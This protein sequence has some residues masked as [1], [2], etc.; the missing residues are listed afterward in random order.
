MREATNTKSQIGLGK[1][2]GLV[3]EV[4]A[5][6]IAVMQTIKK[7]LDPLW[8]MNPGKIFDAGDVTSTKSNKAVTAA[9]HM[10]HPRQ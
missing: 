4:G 9:A 1:K 6:T 7:S 8:I 5:E 2:A 3:K 10:D